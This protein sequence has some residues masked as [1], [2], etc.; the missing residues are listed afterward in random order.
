MIGERE[1]GQLSPA[2]GMVPTLSLRL[3]H[4]VCSLLKQS[5][6]VDQVLAV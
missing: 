2:F 3:T 4:F 6:D 5:L 1:R